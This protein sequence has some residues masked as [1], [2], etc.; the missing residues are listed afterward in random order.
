MS[1]TE[2]DLRTLTSWVASWDELKPIEDEITLVWKHLKELR[3]KAAE[4]RARLLTTC[5]IELTDLEVR[6]W[7]KVEVIDDDTSCW[8]WKSAV[9]PSHGEFYGCFRWTDPLTGKADVPGAHRVAYFL[10]HGTLPDHGR[11]SCNNPICVRP[12]HILN[13]THADN[14]ADRNRRF[15]FKTMRGGEKNFAVRDQRGEGN[16]IAVLTEAM[17]IEARRRVRAGESQT[18]VAADLGVQR[19]TLS[20]ALSGKTWG[21]LNDIAQPIAPRPKRRT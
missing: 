2:K 9:R 14:M 20:Y 15:G 5:P 21:H 12:S 1:S 8:R 16:K 13:G 7:S 18:A 4:T 6:F 19:P 17:V 3:A 11:H 10:T